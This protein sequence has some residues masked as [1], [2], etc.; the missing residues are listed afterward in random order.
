MSCLVTPSTSHR[1]ATISSAARTSRRA[2]LPG[3][4]PGLRPEG[5]TRSEEPWPASAR[6]GTYSAPNVPVGG[7]GR[8]T[9]LSRQAFCRRTSEDRHTTSCGDMHC[10]RRTYHAT[11]AVRPPVSRAEVTARR[12]WLRPIAELGGA[13]SRWTAADPAVSSRWVAAT[14]LLSGSPSEQ[15]VVDGQ[16]V[17]LLVVPGQLLLDPAPPRGTAVGGADH[18]LVDRC[19]DPRPRFGLHL[20]RCAIDLG[21]EHRAQRGGNAD[22]QM[23][24]ALRGASIRQVV[25]DRVFPLAARQQI[26]PLGVLSLQCLG[27]LPVLP[28][29]AQDRP[30]ASQHAI[31]G[32]E[33]G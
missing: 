15:A 24:P 20:D 5:V 6:P 11:R 28:A 30:R 16:V 26:R 9:C 1:P 3:R 29:H 14:R 33:I 8:G 17:G 10:R 12:P 22:R 7:A 27:E 19:L 4:R 32:V 2:R 18:A 21:H 23:R 31:G 25:G 13:A